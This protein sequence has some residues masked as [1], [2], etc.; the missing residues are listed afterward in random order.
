MAILKAIEGHH[1]IETIQLE[2]A[3]LAMPHAAGCAIQAAGGV[4]QLPLGYQT[5]LAAALALKL[6]DAL[7]GWSC[8][9]AAKSSQKWAS[10]GTTTARR[11]SSMVTGLLIE[12][13]THTRTED[14]SRILDTVAIVL[15]LVPC[16]AY[17]QVGQLSRGYIARP[18]GCGHGGLPDGHSR[19]LR[20]CTLLED[21]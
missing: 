7:L 21:P 4:A 1:I 18:R 6:S 10:L 20:L 16:S 12:R 8:A 3:L 13:H 14:S 19:N 5:A 9:V 17:L 15:V 11:A 2:R